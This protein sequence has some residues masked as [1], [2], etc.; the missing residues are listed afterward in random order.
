MKGTETGMPM[1]WVFAIFAM[2]AVAIGF[3]IPRIVHN[4]AFVQAGIYASMAL[5]SAVI[6]LLRS[7]RKRRTR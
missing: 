1:T 7:G 4:L 2:C 3:A 5:A 6:G